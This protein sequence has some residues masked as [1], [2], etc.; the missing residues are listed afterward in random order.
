VNTPPCPSCLSSYTMSLSQIVIAAST[1]AGVLGVTMFSA[2]WRL[3]NGCYCWITSILVV[4]LAWGLIRQSPHT[5]MC[6]NMGR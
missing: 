2:I 6:L 3:T 4:R 5:S 1:S